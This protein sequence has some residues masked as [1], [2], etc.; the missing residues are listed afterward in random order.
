MDA[1]IEP[2]TSASVHRSGTEEWVDLTFVPHEDAGA[3]LRPSWW[4]SYATGSGARNRRLYG[5]H[6]PYSVTPAVRP[7]PLTREDLG[8]EDE[9]DPVTV[10]QHGQHGSK[11]YA[12]DRDPV[13]GSEFCAWHEQQ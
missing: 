13:E 4:P 8:P 10:C 7:A 5:P 11:I 2:A 6:R 12:C 1:R 9:L 3:D